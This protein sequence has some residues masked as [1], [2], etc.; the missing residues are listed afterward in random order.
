MVAPLSRA[1]KSSQ[2][3]IIQPRL[4]GQA[5]TLPGL[6][7]CRVCASSP[8]LRGVT[9]VQGMALGSPVVKIWDC[10]QAL[11]VA[12]GV[13]GNARLVSGLSHHSEGLSLTECADAA[14]CC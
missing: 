9:W 4:L 5:S 3:P 13:V 7:S 10:E 6:T 12:E 14:L 8:A 2:G 1:A 11:W